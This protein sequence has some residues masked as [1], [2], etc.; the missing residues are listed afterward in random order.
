MCNNH[1]FYI[2]YT[3][4]LKRRLTEHIMRKDYKGNCMKKYGYKVY[5]LCD[6]L[7]LEEALHVEARL[8]DQK[9]IDRDDTLNLIIGGI[10]SPMLN[11]D[12][13]AKRKGIKPSPE[14]I[15]KRVAKMKGRPSPLRG[16]PMKQETKD[17]LS[18]VKKGCKPWNKGK[19]NTQK[20]N[21]GTFAKGGHCGEKHPRSKV[22]DK[23]REEMWALRKAGHKPPD[24][25][26]RFNISRSQV[27]RN[28]RYI[29]R[30]KNESN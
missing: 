24:I 2:G 12:I 25:A 17:L 23:D 28:I 20:P 3:K 9:F 29:E 19:K 10:S 22:S 21:S 13:A 4:D 7:T 15:Q 5:V 27:F 14:S 26:S 16:I 18:R 30:L 6:D 11:P 8:V 1:K